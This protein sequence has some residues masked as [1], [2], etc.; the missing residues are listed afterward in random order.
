MARMRRLASRA[1]NPLVR[2]VGA[3]ARHGSDEAARRIPLHRRAARA[4]RRARCARSRPVELA[5]RRAQGAPGTGCGIPEPVHRSVD[6]PGHPRAV[7]GR[8]RHRNVAQRRQVDGESRLPEQL[9][10]LD[11]SASSG[12]RSRDWARPRRSPFSRLRTRSR[13]SARSGVTTAR[14]SSLVTQ[15]NNS[16]RLSLRLHREPK[17]SPTS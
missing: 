13:S 10:A 7:R 1:D 9:P 14:S 3:L 17:T 16:Q 8:Q 5:R 6:R 2:A 11:R 12:P 15:I 4:R